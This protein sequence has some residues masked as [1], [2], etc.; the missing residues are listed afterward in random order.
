MS[1]ISAVQP[2]AELIDESCPLSSDRLHSHLIAA[3]RPVLT[4]GF[5]H[6]GGHKN[7]FE[8]VC[9][10]DGVIGPFQTFGILLHKCAR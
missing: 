4:P 1:F 8:G 9:C 3:R 2:S 5:S 10:K 6:V 7:P